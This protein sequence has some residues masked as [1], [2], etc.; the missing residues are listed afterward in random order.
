[1]ADFHQKADI[2]SY[3]ILNYQ[4]SRFVDAD[5]FSKTFGLEF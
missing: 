4:K 5:K 3:A 1:M 2:W